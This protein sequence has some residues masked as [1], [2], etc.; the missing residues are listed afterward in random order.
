MPAWNPSRL[1]EWRPDPAALKNAARAAIVVPAAFALTTALVGGDHAPIFAAFGSFALLALVEFSGRTRSRV[2]AYLGMAATGAV[3]IVIGTLCSNGIVLA[4]LV[5]GVVTFLIFFSGVINGYLAAA[6]TAAVLLIAL[7]VMIP[8][9][10]SA[11]DERLAGWGIAC[12]IAIPSIFLIWRSPWAAELRKGCS[13][14]CLALARLIDDPDS[15][16]ARKDAEDA[17]RSVRQRFLQTPHRPTGPTG[18]A[19]AVAALIEELGWLVS[20][21]WR[22]GPSLGEGAGP[23]PARVRAASVS[24]LEQTSRMIL[25]HEGTVSTTELDEARQDLIHEFAARVAKEDEDREEIMEDLARTF[26]LRLLSFSVAEIAGFA[27]VASGGRDAPGPLGERWRR[28]LGRSRKKAAVTEQLLVEHVDPRSAWLR[29]SL[30]GAIAIALAVFVADLVAAENAFWVV[31]GTLSV[32]RSNAVGTEGSVVSALIGTTIGIVIGGA[33]IVLIGESSVLLWVALPLAVLAAGFAPRAISFAAGQAAF[34]VLV[35]ILFNLIEPIGVQVGL[36]RVEDVALGCAVSLAVGLLMWPRG[37]RALIRDCL[38]EAYD[39]SS[40]MVCNRVR[41]ALEGEVVDPRDPVRGEAVAAADRMDAALRQHLD[42]SSA[43]HS[44]AGNL[45]ALVACS[46]RLIRSSHAFRMM[47]LMPWYSAPPAGLIPGIAT[48]NDDV[49]DWYRRC[50]EAIEG[51][52]PLPAPGAIPHSLDDP[53]V[54]GIAG[55]SGS[56]ELHAALS[57]A[58]LI[59]GLEYLVFLEGRVVDHADRLFARSAAEEKDLQ[60]G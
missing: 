47:V 3:L 4:T 17:V 24:L 33:V 22:P 51:S 37:A 34:S 27:N 16:D 2:L 14:A 38:A 7:P 13:R 12:A 31:L 58:W 59:Q 30:R 40:R 60:V 42:E 52:A 8:A 54:D 11:I 48:L 20:Q 19:A 1:S 53:V 36:V 25:T 9:D 10:S 46:A 41:A 29:N 18:S 45:V 5:S 39:S 43:A 32:L 50:A 15:P 44:D 6:R 23:G 57:A 26:R 28:V 49:R 55:A 21:F 35:M 56:A